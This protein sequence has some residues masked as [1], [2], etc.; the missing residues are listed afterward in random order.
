MIN[1]I[2]FYIRIF[3]L[4]FIVKNDNIYMIIY[5]LSAKNLRSLKYIV[6]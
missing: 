1:N 4:E 3:I 2:I 5:Y 6:K